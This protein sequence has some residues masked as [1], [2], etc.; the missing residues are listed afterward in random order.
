MDG[1]LALIF[2]VCALSCVE[3]FFRVLFMVSLLW[4]FCVFLLSVIFVVHHF[5]IFLQFTFRLMTGYALLLRCV[6]S[7]VYMFMNCLDKTWRPLQM[8]KIELVPSAGRQAGT[9]IN[10]AW[11]FALNCSWLCLIICEWI[12]YLFV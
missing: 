10:Q 5:F 9:W 11:P 1:Q 7:S 3:I 12:N 6:C 8:R 2:C 4:I